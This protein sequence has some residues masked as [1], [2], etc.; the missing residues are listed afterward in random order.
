M[1]NSF[2]R[3]N[4]AESKKSQEIGIKIISKL[5]E[6]VDEFSKKYNL[7]FT[8]A[9]D[10]NKE[11]AR[12]F[13]EFDRVIFG[14]IENVT[15]KDSYTLSFEIPKEYDNDKKIKVEAP[16]HEYTNGGHITRIETNDVENTIKEMNKNE[17][18]YLKVSYKK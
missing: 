12:D 11:I 5:K 15:D 18:G 2:N 8:L 17:I 10:Y 7:T 16:Y 14:R 13:I 3:K 1:F 6:K 4:H 9:G